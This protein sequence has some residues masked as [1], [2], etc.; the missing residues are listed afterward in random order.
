MP[1][2]VPEV[3]RLADNIAAY[4]PYEKQGVAVFI[5]GGGVAIYHDDGT[6][7]GNAGELGAISRAVVV[8]R[9]RALA[10]FIEMAAP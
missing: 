10:S 4:M 9:L 1:N 6:V 5:G 8:A 2:P 7:M 3:G